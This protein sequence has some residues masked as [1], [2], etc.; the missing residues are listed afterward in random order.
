M[1]FV[2]NREDILILKN[3]D[4]CKYSPTNQKNRGEERNTKPSKQESHPST[5]IRAT[6]KLPP[7]VTSSFQSTLLCT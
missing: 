1:S 6:R 3:F 7:H 4:L 2:Y 5:R